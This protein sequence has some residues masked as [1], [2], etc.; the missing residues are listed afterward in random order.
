MLGSRSVGLFANVGSHASCACISCI[1]LKFVL[2]K[3]CG[4]YV[5]HSML[6]NG[7]G[8]DILFF[9][10]LSWSFLSGS[11]MTWICCP[12][13]KCVLEL[14]LHRCCLLG[15]LLIKLHIAIISLCYS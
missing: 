2:L 4:I 7:H 15:K 1:F 5:L 6:G 9:S 13:G 10:H 3:L 12:V 11:S 14:S 8:Y